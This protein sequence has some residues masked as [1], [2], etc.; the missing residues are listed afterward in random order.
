MSLNSFIIKKYLLAAG[1]LLVLGQGLW[2]L[3]ELQ[4]RSSPAHN[5]EFILSRASKELPLI[6][7]DLIMLNERVDFLQWFQVHDGPDQ[8]VS[9]NRLL[10]FP[11]LESIRS[12]APKYFWDINLY[13]AHKTRVRVERRL[14]QLAPWLKSLDGNSGVCSSYA[15]PEILGKPFA[16]SIS[17]K[18]IKQFQDQWIDYNAKLIDL[19]KLLNLLSNNNK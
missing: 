8:K 17:M 10:F 2:Q 4:D 11:F 15:S 18:Q 1:L 7:E 9:P 3:P 16:L 12:L 5:L 6:K 13:L 19:T 14:G